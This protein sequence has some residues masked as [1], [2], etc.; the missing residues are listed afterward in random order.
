MT[1]LHQKRGAALI[2]AAVLALIALFGM[3]ACPNNAGGSGTPSTPKYAVNFGVDGGNGTL[4]AKADGGTETDVSPIN[5]EKGK[6]VT[7]TAVPD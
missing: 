5:V 3:T 1:N 7:F 6:T 4:K 2:T